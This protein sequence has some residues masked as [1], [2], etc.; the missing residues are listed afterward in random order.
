MKS[1][2]MVLTAFSKPLSP[3]ENEIPAL[4]EGE[5]LVKME[6]S[7]ICGSDV[8]MWEGEDSRTPLPI[9]LGHE[10]VGRV[11]AQNGAHHTVLGQPVKEGDRIVWNR[12]VTCGKCYACRVLLEPWLC[13]NRSVY[14]INIP[15]DR[16]PFLNGCYS[17]YII[18]SPQTDLFLAPEGVDPAVLV[19]AGCSGATTANA[20]DAVKIN[21]GDTVVILGPGPLGVYAAAFA[22]NAGAKQIVVIGGS[23]ARLSLCREF[24]ATQVINRRVLSEDER[25]EAVKALTNGRGADLVVEAAGTNGVARET[26]NL[27]RAGGTCVM[28]GY[29]QPAGTEEIDFFRQVVRKHITVKGIWVSDARHT[30]QAMELVAANPALFAK[31]V[32]HRFPLEQADEALRVMK[33][34]EAL[35]SV[36]IF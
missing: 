23:E 12:G 32:T 31:L 15:A 1:R 35:K 26:M 21:P 24:G 6:A 2:A 36:L 13:E 33:T 19:S 27:A 3:Q 10:G 4:K 8:H 5:I 22:K 30:L 9:I 28:T 7:G 34:K 16:A 25:L 18:L 11:A 17:E 14:G 20:F 29:A